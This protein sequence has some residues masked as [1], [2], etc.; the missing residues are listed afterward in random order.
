MLAC[1]GVGLI[2]DLRCRGFQ[3]YMTGPILTIDP[4]N[5]LTSGERALISRDWWRIVQYFAPVGD[6][7]PLEA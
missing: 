7:L 4:G 1:D 2:R 3:V 6:A 5:E